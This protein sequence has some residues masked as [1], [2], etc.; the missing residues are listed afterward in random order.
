[1]KGIFGVSDDLVL[2]IDRKTC[3]F[4]LCKVRYMY[5]KRLEVITHFN[6]AKQHLELQD[7]SKLTGS[8]HALSSS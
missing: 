1:M 4:S 5:G 7:C 2:E 6:F 3:V 8:T